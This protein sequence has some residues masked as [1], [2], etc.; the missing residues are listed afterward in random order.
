MSM[1]ID[2]AEFLLSTMLHTKHGALTQI[3]MIEAIRH[4]S[5]FIE[6]RPA[7]DNPEAPINPA[8]WLEIAKEIRQKIH[9]K[10]EVNEPSLITLPEN[11]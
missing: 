6:G 3:F 9:L 5:Q 4:Y 11:F 8:T 7:E 1:A 10:Y 2:N